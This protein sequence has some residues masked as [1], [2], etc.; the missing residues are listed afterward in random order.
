MHFE[1]VANQREPGSWKLKE[2]KNMR[3]EKK[4]WKS[5]PA[6]WNPSREIDAV[7]YFSRRMLTLPVLNLFEQHPP[8][9]KWKK[10]ESATFDFSLPNV[11]LLKQREWTSGF[12]IGLFVQFRG[13]GATR[14]TLSQFTFLHYIKIAD[15]QTMGFWN[16]ERVGRVLYKTVKS[17]QILF[18]WHLSMNIFEDS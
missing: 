4:S 2:D 17:W 13:K 3:R 8:V 12:F 15:R 7:T 1:N 14:P 6:S 9:L 18:C 10:Q 16:C 5:E 11:P